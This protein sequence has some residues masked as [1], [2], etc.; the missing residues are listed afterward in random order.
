VFKNVNILK[1]KGNIIS[2][3]FLYILLVCLE[4]KGEILLWQSAV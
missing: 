3:K 2:K 1:Q 4:N